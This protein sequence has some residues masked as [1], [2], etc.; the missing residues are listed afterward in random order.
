MKVCITGAQ[1]FIGGRLAARYRAAGAEVV[2]VDASV[3]PD[4]SWVVRGDVAEPG[5]WQ[6]A[7]DGCANEDFFGRYAAMLGIGLPVASAEEVRAILD[8]AGIGA[9]TV[10][11]LLRRGT[12]SIEKAGRVLGFEPAVSLDEGMARTERWLRDQGMLPG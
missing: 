4:T 9:E 5:D 3:A 6:Q 7:A 8:R 12:Y 1:G 11:Y 2:G 10:D